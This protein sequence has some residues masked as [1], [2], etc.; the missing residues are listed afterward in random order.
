MP[1]HYCS[2]CTSKEKCNLMK[3]G[4]ARLKENTYK[5][6]RWSQKS[7]P[8][9][10]VDNESMSW[11]LPLIASTIFSHVPEN[12]IQHFHLPQTLMIWVS[13]SFKL[14]T[15][16]FW[17][18]MPTVFSSFSAHIYPVYTS[19]ISRFRVG[20]C[21]KPLV[22]LTSFRCVTLKPVTLELLCNCIIDF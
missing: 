7:P 1:V 13:F 9:F 11:L 6:I 2:F 16:K 20:Y 8:K 17:S 15:C 5:C 18:L 4:C 14:I 3:M 12:Q 10:D 21:F 22:L 19:V